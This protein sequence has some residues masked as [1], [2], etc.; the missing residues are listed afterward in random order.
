MNSHNFSWNKGTETK[1]ADLFTVSQ[2]NKR[3]GL[4]EEETTKTLIK[5]QKSI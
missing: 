5:Q 1:G 3:Q 4:A 2:R